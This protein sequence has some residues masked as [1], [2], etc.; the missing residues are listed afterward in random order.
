[1]AAVVKIAATGVMSRVTSAPETVRREREQAAQRA[2][3]IVQTF[4]AKERM[5]PAVVLDDKEPHEQAGGRNRE[6]ER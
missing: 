5:M 1:M 3:R 6:Q 2:Q 4:T